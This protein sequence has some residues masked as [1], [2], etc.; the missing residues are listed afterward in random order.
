M[1]TYS[2]WLRIAG[3]HAPAR[4]VLEE[5]APWLEERGIL[6]LP[7]ASAA[8][9]YAQIDLELEHQSSLYGFDEDAPPL[10]LGYAGFSEE[11]RHNFLLWT[12][13]L[14]RAA[15]P[16]FHQLLCASLEVWLL[17]L[18]QTQ[19]GNLLRLREQIGKLLRADSWLRDPYLSHLWL[20]DR[21]LNPTLPEGTDVFAMEVL[22]PSIAGVTLG[23]QAQ[24]AE[25][26]TPMQARW[27]ST[28]WRIEADGM[29]PTLAALRLD[30]ASQRGAD[31]LADSLAALPESALL[32]RSFR[33]AHR[34]LR[35]A[36][37]QPDLR[38]TLEPRLRALFAPAEGFAATLDG[39][40]ER[41]DGQA[42]GED[43][44]ES[45]TLPEPGYE[46]DPPE[47]IELPKKGKGKG[48]AAASSEGAKEWQLIV[49]FSEGRSQYTSF[50]LEVAQ[51]LPGYT[52]LLDENRTIVHR[53]YMRKSELR[54]FWRLW[55]YI[56]GWS[57]THV[58]LNGKELEKWQIWPWS[59][60]LR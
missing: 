58:Y 21:V 45:V 43:S 60:Y 49:E 34:D 53:V 16:A 10:G 36:L 30:E 22:A 55:D 3:T 57:N 24:R 27:L 41:E 44:L 59:H 4:Q 39:E 20:L 35:I 1:S 14:E 23:I 6:V 7:S 56:Q 8:N 18:S 46:S 52:T 48:A 26:M 5:A 32:P 54:R 38:P 9:D 33:A 19:G 40:D 50:A 12:E 29:D 28:I 25:S 15:S 37:P 2:R 17:S 47:R 31:L 11:Q 51:K 42:N 13:Q